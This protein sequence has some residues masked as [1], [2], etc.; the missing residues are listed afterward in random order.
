VA[1]ILGSDRRD[2]YDGR[3]SVAIETERLSLC[4]PSYQ[5]YQRRGTVNQYDAY[6]ALVRATDGRGVDATGDG[7]A[8][9]DPTTGISYI[10]AYTYSTQGDQI[11]VST[12]P[13]TTTVNGTPRANTP[14]VT[15]S[16]YDGDGNEITSTSANGNPTTSAYDHLGRLVQTTLPPVKLYDNTT[17]TPVETTGYDGDGNVVATHDASGALTTDSYDPLGR[18]VA[19]T[20]PVSGAQLM[21]YTATREAF[22]QDPGGALTAYRYNAG[23]QVNHVSDPVSGTVDYTYNAVGAITAITT[24]DGTTGAIAAVE[25]RGYDALN[26]V[27][28]DSVGR[29]TTSTQTTQTAYD[30]DGN[31]AGALQPHGDAVY[32]V[33]DLA[34]QLVGMEVDASATRGGP[35]IVQTAYGYDN[36]GNQ[37]EAI[38]FNGRTHTA[39]Y[40]A[41]NRVTQ[42]TDTDPGGSPTTT[43]T[44][45]YDPDGNTVTRIMQAAGSPAHT[46]SATYD[47]GDQRVSATEDGATTGYGFDALGNIRSQALTSGAGTGVTLTRLLDAEDRTLG[48]AERLSGTTAYTTTFGYTTN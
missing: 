5:T 13:L 47:A 39:T 12:P 33:Y 17:T 15:T 32:N 24:S 8:T 20:N 29:P 38:D 43:T 1:V 23:G 21:T 22:D 2:T 16:T 37:V 35:G 46:Y 19:E 30:L 34:D 25:T 27:I 41:D 42:A 14:V 3:H 10:S 45:A 48:I 11:A 31:V 40:D 26:R 4:Q 36:A 18:L 9:L 44:W 7:V 6:G 28:T